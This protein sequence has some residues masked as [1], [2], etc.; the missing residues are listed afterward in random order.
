LAIITAAIAITD[1]LFV[2]SK[3][4]VSKLRIE[5]AFFSPFAIGNHWA[6]F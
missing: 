2:T 1:Y 6:K 4:Y 3:R 5:S